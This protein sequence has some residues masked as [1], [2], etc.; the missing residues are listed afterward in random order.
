MDENGEQENIQPLERPAPTITEQ[1]KGQPSQARYGS[2]PEKK[3]NLSPDGSPSTRAEHQQ[4]DDDGRGGTNSARA[5]W[6]EG[7]GSGRG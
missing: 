5:A 3:T 4:R 6:V 7:V 2:L 1:R